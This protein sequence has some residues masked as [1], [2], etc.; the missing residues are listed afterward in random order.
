MVGHTLEFLSG[1]ANQLSLQNILPA[2]DNLHSEINSIKVAFT[3][4]LT[5]SDDEYPQLS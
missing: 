3:D 1:K 4:A 2:Q 5:Q